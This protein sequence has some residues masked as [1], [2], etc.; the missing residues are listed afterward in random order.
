MAF[1]QMTSQTSWEMYRS[2]WSEYVVP[3]QGKDHTLV[4]RLDSSRHLRRFRIPPPL[5]AALD[6]MWN[7]SYSNSFSLWSIEV[8]S[9]TQKNGFL[10]WHILEKFIGIHSSIQQWTFKNVWRFN[11]WN[12]Y[13]YNFILGYGR[14]LKSKYVLCLATQIRHTSFVR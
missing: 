7:N 10:S 8:P 3:A 2:C 9:H 12:M 14:Y 5:P 6:H 11:V 13:I 1:V 4:S